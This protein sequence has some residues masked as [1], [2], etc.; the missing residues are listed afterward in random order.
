MALISRC[1]DFAEP[2]SPLIHQNMTPP[3]TTRALPYFSTHDYARATPIKPPSK[4]VVKANLR[5][6]QGQ[7][8]S[9]PRAFARAAPAIYH[10]WTEWPVRRVRMLGAPK[11]RC[12]FRPR[13]LA[14]TTCVPAGLMDVARAYLCV[15][16]WRC[17]RWC[18]EASFF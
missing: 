4:H 17:P 5:E 1:M 8:A 12:P 2:F 13:K 6:R 16:N 14:S 11:R 10:F 7:R 18:R 9:E 3:Y 15:E